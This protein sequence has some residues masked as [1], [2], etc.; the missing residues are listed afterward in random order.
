[1]ECARAQLGGKKFRV[2]PPLISCQDSYY[3]WRYSSQ[4]CMRYEISYS[5][6]NCV[7]IGTRVTIVTIDMGSSAMNNSAR[8]CIQYLNTRIMNIG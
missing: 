7:T 2:P 4:G 5:I 8:K 1:M 3:R 6:S